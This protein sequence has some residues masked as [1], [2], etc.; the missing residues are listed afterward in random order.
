M[1]TIVDLT[2]QQKAALDAHAQRAGISC[3][4]AIRRAVDCYLSTLATTEVPVDDADDPAFGIWR[5]RRLDS[6]TL[7]DTLR[8]EWQARSSAVEQP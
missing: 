8:D 2:P 6:L 1:R 5:N 3:A 7:E 4:E